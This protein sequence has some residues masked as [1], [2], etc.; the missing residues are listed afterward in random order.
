MYKKAIY[1]NIDK[2]EGNETKITLN[3]DKTPITPMNITN[4]LT[5]N[6]P[7]K[8]NKVPIP[9]KNNVEF[10]KECVDDNHK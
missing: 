7:Q 8:G 10:S 9:P 2:L 4:T 1:Y 3:M 5:A 6:L